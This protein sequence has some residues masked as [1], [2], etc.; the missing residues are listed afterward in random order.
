MWLS[1]FLGG[2]LVDK[3]SSSLQ[4]NVPKQSLG[5]SEYKFP[6]ILTF[7]LKGEGT[8]SLNFADDD[9]VDPVEI[10]R[11][12]QHAPSGWRAFGVTNLGLSLRLIIQVI[13]LTHY[14]QIKSYHLTPSGNIYG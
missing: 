12:E 9:I 2:T 3:A 5:A 8:K 10:P 7:S 11:T 1:D 4:N 13:G 14:P 6:L